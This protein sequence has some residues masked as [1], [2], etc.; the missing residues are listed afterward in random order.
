MP[1]EK[2]INNLNTNSKE[3][4]NPIELPKSDNFMKFNSIPNKTIPLTNSSTNPSTNPTETTKI[5]GKLIM[6]FTTPTPTE[7]KQVNPT[8][9][10]K[11]ANLFG[12]GKV[13][14]ALKSPFL[15][16]TS[17]QS[18][19]EAPESKSVQHGVIDKNNLGKGMLMGM[20]KVPENLTLNKVES[21]NFKNVYIVIN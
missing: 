21:E 9:P 10:I 16:Q 12:G 8:I 1:I 17:T 15:T 7:T 3:E 19:G 2:Q 11:D 18:Q 4:K 20:L 13:M 14:G 5:P 6:P